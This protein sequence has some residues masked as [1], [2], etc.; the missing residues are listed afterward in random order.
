MERIRIGLIGFGCVGQGL[1]HVLSQTRGIKAEVV[2]ICVKDRTKARSLPAELFTYEVDDLINDPSVA[3]VVELIDDAEKAYEYVL[4]AMHAG[5]DVV[6]ANKKM[7]A[8]HLQELIDLQDELGV[9]LLY[10]ASSCGSIPIIRNLEEYYDNELLNSVSGI[11]N[12]SS[13]YIL[14]KVCSEGQAYE[15]ALATAQALGFAETDPTL[16]VAGFDALYKLVIIATHAF[17]VVVSPDEVFN[18][19]IQSLTAHDQLFAQQNGYKIKLQCTVTRLGQDQL[20]M[21]VMPAFVTP[22]SQLY[23]VENEYNA[24]SVEAAFADKQLF[25]GKGAGGSPTGAAVLSDI[26][27][28]TYGYKYAYKKQAQDLS[29]TYTSQALVTI[30]LGYQDEQYLN[31]FDFWDVSAR[32]QG[33]EHNYLIGRVKLKD[34]IRIKGELVTMPVFLAQMPGTVI[35]GI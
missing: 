4:K 29:L 15:Q 30:Y 31:H 1:Y 17:G 7:L 35:E 8:N 23:N 18:T 27:A 13:N 34:L 21:M 32:Y 25:I 26:S 11:F 28:L 6:T 19:G 24:V 20:T 5:K 16:D 3:V 10:E 22:E 2:K 9:K 33:R 12:G 14:T